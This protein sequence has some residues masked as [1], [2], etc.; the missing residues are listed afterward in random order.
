MKTFCAVAITV[1]LAVAS[2]SAFAAAPTIRLTPNIS[3]ADGGTTV[4]AGAACAVIPFGTKAVD[5]QCDNVQVYVRRACAPPTVNC[6]LDAGLGD[7][8]LD[9]RALLNNDGGIAGRT[10]A[11]VPVQLRS[12][13]NRLCARNLAQPPD[14]AV[15]DAGDTFN[16]FINENT[17][18]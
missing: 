11:P 8:V 2:L 9:F 16:C 12:N 15:A 17:A 6:V 3:L 18:Y 5:L 10:A 14:A 4:G 1:A 7:R 13:E